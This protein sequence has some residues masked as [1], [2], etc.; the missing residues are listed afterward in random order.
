[1]NRYTAATTLAVALLLNLVSCDELPEP[2]FLQTTDQVNQAM[3]A[4]EFVTNKLEDLTRLN[5]L[6]YNDLTFFDLRDLEAGNTY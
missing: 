3:K 6:L 2:F 4:K 1:M 5:C